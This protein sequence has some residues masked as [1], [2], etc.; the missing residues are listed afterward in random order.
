MKVRV[1]SLYRYNPCLLD[2]IDG[3]TNAIKG[4]CYRVINKY[5]CPPA[6]TMGQCYI[7]TIDGEFLGMVS[8]SSLEPIKII[9]PK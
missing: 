8:T 1:N 4:H 2:L 7:E 3:R 5:G 9:Q 6:N